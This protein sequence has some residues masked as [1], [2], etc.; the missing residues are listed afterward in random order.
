MNVTINEKRL[1]FTPGETVLQVARRA[2]INIPHLCSLDWAPSPSASCR[3]CVV[4]VEGMPRLQ[5]SCTLPAAEGMVVRTHTPRLLKARRAIVELLVANHPQD[6]LTCSRSGSCELAELAG[7]LGVRQRRYV[8]SKKD[9]PIDISSPAIWR[10]PNKCVLCGRCVTMCQQVQGVGAVDFTGRGFRTQ[11]APGFYAGLNVSGCVYCGQCVRVCP[12]G[13]LMERSHVDAVVADLGDPNTVV[14]VQIAPAVPATLMKGRSKRQDVSATLERLAAALKHVGFA[15]VF[16]TAFAADLTIMEEATELLHRVQEGG[17]L[18]MFTSCSPAWVHFV[19]THR[20]DLIPHLSTCKSPQQMAGALIKE[21]YPGY[22]GLD[23]KRLV[24]VSLM[25][26]T[27]KKFEAQ[28]QGDV[29]YVLTTREL[30]ALWDRFGVDFAAFDER[31][32]LDA[33]FA[34][35]T[36]AGRLFAGSGGVMEAAVRTA[37]VLIDPDGPP[38]QLISEARG[39][40]GVKCFNVEMGGTTLKLGV[41]NGLGRLRPALDEVLS[42]LHFVEVMSCPGGC[43]GG[44]GQ[45]YGSEIE[46]VRRR[47][48]RLYEA[49]EHADARSS[50]QNTE[51]TALYEKLLGRPLSEVSHRLLHREYVDRSGFANPEPDSETCLSIAPGASGSLAMASTRG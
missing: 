4:E 5:T 38:V 23:G 11:V 31:A 18:P 32:P 14:V 9:Q 36:G 41:I 44:G 35:V 42:D 45:P 8:G 29:D 6:C 10:D 37:A 22:S 1:K 50:H 34:E 40:D 49:D 16:D 48:D 12:T 26:C 47:Q 27:A 15:A 17:V 24:V 46:D 2:G 28:D 39:P 51:V 3:L 13:A 30:D 19:E 43:V 33:P 21:V 25:P 20:P 7:D